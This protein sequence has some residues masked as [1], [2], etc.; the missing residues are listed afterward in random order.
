MKTEESSA[1]YNIECATNE[2]LVYNDG[3]LLEG[4][5]C[6]F[7]SISNVYLSFCLFWKLY[8][9]SF[10]EPNLKKSNKKN[11]IMLHINPLILI[12]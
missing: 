4:R 7:K 11:P 2:V 5:F 10:N 12:T 1:K 8:Y 9:F 6:S 3:R